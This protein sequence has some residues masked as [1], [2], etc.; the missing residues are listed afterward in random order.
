MEEGS[1]QSASALETIYLLDDKYYQKLGEVWDH[2]TKDFKV[3][4]KPLYSCP[5]K[6]SSYE[7][8]H[9]ATSTFERWHR[10]FVPITSLVDHCLPDFLCDY[11][12]NQ[13]NLA[14]LTRGNSSLPFT[15]KPLSKFVQRGTVIGNVTVPPLIDS[16]PHEGEGYRICQT[17][18]GYGSRSLVPYHVIHFDVRWK[19]PILTGT[20]KATSRVLSRKANQS[21]TTDL[22]LLLEEYHA[23]QTTN[24]IVQAVCD[25][26]PSP[27]LS[28]IASRSPSM[29]FATLQIDRIVEYSVRDLPLELA[30]TEGFLDIP[31]F[32]SCLREYY[33]TLQDEDAVHVFHFHRTDHS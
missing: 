28:S 7:A 19:D 16:L 2:E 5:S 3:L 30:L 9:L 1:L 21:E 13:S 25:L 24:L 31:S 22:H 18:S 10:K 11:L 26:P 33:P 20:K 15:T 8:H 17:E 4:Y 29:V 23:N 14:A 6:H 27:S 12:L 32:I